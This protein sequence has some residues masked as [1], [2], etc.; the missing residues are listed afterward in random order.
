MDVGGHPKVNTIYP[1]NHGPLELRYGYSDD[2]GGG[3]VLREKK[4]QGAH[5]CQPG[6]PSW[7]LSPSVPAALL[8]GSCL[9]P[10]HLQAPLNPTVYMLHLVCPLVVISQSKDVCLCS[11]LCPQQAD[12]T[13]QLFVDGVSEGWMNE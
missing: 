2:L 5:F 10:P 4:Q 6:F 13:R 9:L 11:L 12:D 3:T 1:G 8:P 7:V